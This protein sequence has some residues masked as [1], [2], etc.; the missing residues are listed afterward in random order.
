[1]QNETKQCQSC[2]KEF[3]IDSD[4]F[5]FYEQMKVPPPT[6]CPKCRMIRRLGSSGYRIL[7]KRKCDFTGDTI[8]SSFAPDADFKVYKQ[9]IWWS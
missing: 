5:G 8:I 2:K 3:T 4:D 1:M 6:W 9:D 7:Y